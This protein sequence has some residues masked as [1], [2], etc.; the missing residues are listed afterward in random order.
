MSE[1]FAIYVCLWLL[2][3]A[4]SIL[5]QGKLK[6]RIFILQGG[7]LAIFAAL[8]FETGF[9]WPIYSAHYNGNIADIGLMFEPG[10][11]LLVQS[12]IRLGFGFKYYLSVL[13]IL[14]VAAIMTILWNLTP[15][16]KEIS[17]AVIFAMPDFFLIPVFS[18]LRQTTSL[19]ILMLGLVYQTRGRKRLGN[20]LVFASFLFHYSTIIIFGITWLAR[21]FK[22]SN[23]G[24]IKVFA[25]FSLCYVASVDIF[26]YV[27]NLFIQL[28]IPNYA[29]YLDKDTFNASFAYRLVTALIS[30]GALW[31]IVKAQD[32]STED[33]SFWRHAS[34]LSILLPIALFNFP[35]FTSRFLFLG[36]FSIIGYTLLS[37]NGS[38]RMSKGLI[39]VILSLLLLLPFYRFLASP[40]SS[41]YVPYQSMLTYD[42]RNSTGAERTQELLDM[43]DSLW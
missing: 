6:D 3:L 4:H 35:T 13:S 30:A 15:R 7:I 33:E 9:D 14:M 25:F 21:R 29:Y 2:A 36:G 8:R 19:L 42:E 11:E 28:V 1:Y 10:Y 32:S 39:C 27:L 31:L 17:L 34:L 41:P 16:Y 12:F 40:F 18:V 20:T 5:R 43:L 24:Y 38:L 26:K 23:A 22:I 37:L